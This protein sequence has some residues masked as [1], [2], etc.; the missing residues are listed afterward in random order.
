MKTGLLL[1]LSLVWSLVEV[2]SQTTPYVSLMGQA[3]AN[4]SYVNLTLVGDNDTDGS[5]NTVR[6]ITDLGTCCGGGQ[7]IHRGDWY[8][9]DGGVVPSRPGGPDISRTRGSQRVTLHRRNNA[10]EPTG[11]YHCE[12]PTVA[13]YDDSD[14]SIR[15]TVYVGLYLPSEGRL[16]ANT[17][18]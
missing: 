1:L 8:F 5:H 14:T 9:P 4:H 2:H 12:V 16:Y 13:V 10:M 18:Q 11:I 7:G 6:C 15:E 3:L 17:N